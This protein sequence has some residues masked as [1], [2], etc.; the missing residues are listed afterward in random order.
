M[1]LSRRDMLFA[2]AGALSTRCG[3]AVPAANA[4]GVAAFSYNLRLGRERELRDPL[5]FLQ[6]CRARGAG[7]AQVGIPADADA[8]AL[9]RALDETRMWLEG[10]VRLPRDAGDVERFDAEVRAAKAAGATVLRTV[11]LSGRRYET[12]AT[13]D[14]FRRFRETST[15][16]VQLAAPV[17]ERHGVQLAV[18]NHKDYRADEQ[19]AL[20]RRI[21]SERIGVCLDTGNNLALLEEPLETVA[22]LAPLAF[23]VHL[24]DMAVDECPEGFLLSE[25][26]FG[27]GFLDL[28]RVTET[29]Q[30]AQPL[31]RFNVE[32]ITRDPLVVPCL[33]EKYWATFP[34]LPAPVLARALASVREH[35]QG[36]PLPRVEGLSEAERLQREDDNVRECLAYAARQFRG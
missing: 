23:T 21:G 19:V 31:I 25:V 8:A 4:V 35:P 26:P 17:V 36:R 10:S 13:V 15:R 9:R 16:S 2:A 3:A 32:M 28:R 18:E 33:R 29:I 34:Q 14:D 6:F 1:P 11:M 24:K 12:F 20:L 7:G 30:R 22:A 5:R 27:K